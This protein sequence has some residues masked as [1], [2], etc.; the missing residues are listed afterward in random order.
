MR[1]YFADGIYSLWSTFIKTIPTPQ[2]TKRSLFVTT[3]ESTRKDVEHAFGVLQTRFA[4]VRGP[5]HLWRIEALDYIRK[6]CIILHNMIIEDE[7]DANR[8]ED[9]DYEQ[10]LESILIIVSHESIEEFSQF[11]TFIAAHEK[12]RNRENSF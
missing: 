3:Q 8:A 6:A 5:T 1:Y 7:R 9:F 4:I 10:V 2:G 12:I 11:T